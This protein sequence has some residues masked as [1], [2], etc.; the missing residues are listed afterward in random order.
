MSAVSGC[1]KFRK[2]NKV[3]VK[4]SVYRLRINSY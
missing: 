2:N 3:P 4:F 1:Q